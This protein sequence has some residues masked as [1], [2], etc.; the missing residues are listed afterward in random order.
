MVNKKDYGIAIKVDSAFYLQYGSEWIH[1]QVPAIWI[2]VSRDR[3]QYCKP[4]E[5][6][7]YKDTD[8]SDFEEPK[9]TD[10]V[11]SEEDEEKREVKKAPSDAGD[12]V[13]HHEWFTLP[14]KRV[15]AYSEYSKC[16]AG[17]LRHWGL[18]DAWTGAV[19]WLVFARAYIKHCRRRQLDVSEL[20][21][22][23]IQRSL[24][25]LY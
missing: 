1:K 18:H 12:D 14:A 6:S 13:I 4:H 21:V 25:I 16:A 9:R 2:N 5:W 20:D 10:D 24:I 11:S 23:H 19:P 22:F 15:Y 7:D 17:P 8:S 3:V